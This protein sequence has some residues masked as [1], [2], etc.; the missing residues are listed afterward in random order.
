MK[1]DIKAKFGAIAREYDQQR[2]MLIPCFEDFYTCIVQCIAYCKKPLKILDIG[3]GTGLLSSFIYEKY[4]ESDYT[5]IDISVEMIGQAKKRFSGLKNFSYIIDDYANYT[6]TGKFDVIVSS[7]SI[8]HLEDTEKE[9]LYSSIFKILEPG[10]VFINGDQFLCRNSLVEDSIH[11]KW[12][13]QIEGSGLSEREVIAA[14]ERMKM[15]KPAT[16]EK[17]IE[18]LEKAGFSQVE[19]MYKYYIFGVLCAM[20]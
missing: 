20:K 19:L 11:V 16:V 12:K 8:H 4:Q 17:N 6:F 3:T 1:D 15:D 10:G 5:L 9:L 14:F 7:L 2:R 18:W 13:A